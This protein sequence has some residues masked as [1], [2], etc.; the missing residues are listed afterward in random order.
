ML[1]EMELREIQISEAGNHQIIVL[2]EKEGQRL[3]P[4]YIGFFE[5]AAMDQ[6]VRGIPTPRPM[7]HD[8]IYN[9]LDAMGARL[10]RVLVDALL[11]DTFHG[12]LVVQN[13]EGREILV[14]TRPSD[15]IVLACKREIPIF[16]A[17]EVLEEVFRHQNES[18]DFE[19]ES[20]ESEDEQ[21]EGDYPF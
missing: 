10:Q 4:I 15:A 1:V 13:P 3:F 7:T 18:T 9:L 5:A 12:K 21:R 14:D 20:G 17:E 8:L 2:G 16:V 11:D 19:T 6:A